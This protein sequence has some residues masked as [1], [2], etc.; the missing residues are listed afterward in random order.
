[1]LA[2]LL[3]L[4]LAIEGFGCAIVVNIITWLRYLSGVRGQRETSIIGRFVMPLLTVIGFV[5]LISMVIDELRSG[6]FHPDS[7]PT[8]VGL[9]LFLGVVFAAEIWWLVVEVRYYRARPHDTQRVTWSR[10]RRW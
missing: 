1:M 5:G 7:S 6:T 9:V 2:M 8:T 4:L 10:S 3:P